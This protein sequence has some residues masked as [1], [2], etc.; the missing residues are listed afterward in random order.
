M[1]TKAA[2]EV[3]VS[4]E[5]TEHINKW[6]DKTG[7]LIMILHKVQEEYRYIPREIALYLSK[8]LNVALAKI[9]GV[10]TFY[11]FFK[12]KKPGKYNIQICIGTACY[13]KGGGDLLHELENLLGIGVGGITPDGLFS[14]EGVRCVGCCGLA[15]LAV[16]SGEI[17]GKIKK[18]QLPDIIA[19]FK[20][21]EA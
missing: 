3:K 16:C 7:G 15:P 18:E 14:F 8:E 19:K 4:K 2:E 17:F 13:L 5:L 21:R 12:L 6:R 10:V 1:F 11:H 9:Y 20:E